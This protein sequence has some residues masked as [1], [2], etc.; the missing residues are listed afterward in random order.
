MGRRGPQPRP[1]S[2]RLTATVKTSLLPD[3]QERLAELADAEGVTPAA[4]VRRWIRSLL[5]ARTT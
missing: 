5:R 1:P 4:L 2:E 3:E